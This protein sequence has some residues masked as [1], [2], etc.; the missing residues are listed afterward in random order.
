MG[1]SA[2]SPVTRDVKGLVLGWAGRAAVALSVYAGVVF[3]AAGTLHWLWGWILLAVVSATTLAEPLVLA[4][5]NPEL[6]AERRRGFGH[7]GVKQW[8]RWI[9]AVAGA[10][11]PMPWIVAGLDLRFGW[12]GAMSQG[13][14]IGGLLAT[15][16]GYT[17][18]TW[19]MGSNAFFSGG[20]RIQSER[21]HV[22]ATGGPYRFTRHPGYLGTI[23]AQLGTP[24][25]L[26]SPWALI[27]AA[28]LAALFVLRTYLED[29]T[30]LRELP[31]YA[32]YAQ[33][34][35]YRLVPAVW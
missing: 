14:H 11:F 6:F 2:G 33:R 31:G 19:A 24:F 12:T 17:L 1:P 10:L 3:G 13:A 18:F 9:T 4:P 25:L 21:S 5:R 35:R 30:L 23:V 28:I 15:S 7:A 20:V 27:P 29:G 8:D 26:G 16:L 34:V 32:A 22:V